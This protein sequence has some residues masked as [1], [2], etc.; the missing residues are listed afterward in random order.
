M[1]VILTLLFVLQATLG[2]QAQSENPEHLINKLN[3]D[4]LYGTCHYVWVLEMESAAADA[5]IEIGKPVTFK[6]IPLLDSPDKGIIAHIVLSHIWI[7]DFTSTSSFEN[8]ETK[9]IV[10]YSY[11]GLLFYEKDGK[12]IAEKDKLTENKKIWTKKL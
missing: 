5:L 2:I 7:K 11:N 1:K 12:M 9:G 8:F 6:L 4:Q 10:E 3:N